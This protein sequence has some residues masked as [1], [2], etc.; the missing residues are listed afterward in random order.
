[1]RFILLILTPAEQGHTDAQNN[2]GVMYLNGE[3][4]AKDYSEAV[5]WYRLAAEQGSY[6]AQVNLGFMYATGKGVSQDYKEAYAWLHM[7]AAQG[8]SDAKRNREIAAKNLS[9]TDLSKAED[10]SRKYYKLYVEP[11]QL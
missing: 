2:L 10:L 9:H 5:K 4:V 8:N 7:A 1:M 3:G 6:Q 11:F